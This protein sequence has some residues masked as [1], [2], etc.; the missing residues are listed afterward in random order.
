MYNNRRQRKTAPSGFPR[1]FACSRV[2]EGVFVQII[3]SIDTALLIVLRPPSVG[4]GFRPIS[5]IVG[6]KTANSDGASQPAATDFD[7][8]NVARPS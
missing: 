8:Q 2:A 6:P 5:D 7:S 1:E 4:T 3:L